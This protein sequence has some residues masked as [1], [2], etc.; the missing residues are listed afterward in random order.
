MSNGA[1]EY[2]NWSEPYRS[3]AGGTGW[4]AGEKAKAW[5]ASAEQHGRGFFGSLADD[6]KLRL[7]NWPPERLAI[8]GV[9]L[10]V[11]GPV[12][13]SIVMIVVGLIGLVMM[14]AMPGMRPLLVLLGMVIAAVC[15][16]VATFVTILGIVYIAFGVASFMKQKD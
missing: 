2:E 3:H 9:V 1:H 15:G 8:R 10:V 14:E 6:L 11:A 5:R 12:V 13:S 16:I 4:S 7:K